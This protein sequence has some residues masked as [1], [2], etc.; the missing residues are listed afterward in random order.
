VLSDKEWGRGGRILHERAGG[1]GGKGGAIGRGKVDAGR[2][3]NGCSFAG[4]GDQ[5]L[6]KSDAGWKRAVGGKG[7]LEWGGG[8]DGGHSGS[9]IGGKLI[10]SS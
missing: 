6:E 9:A 4:D 5:V 1:G 7:G 10:R 3:K 2:R 8:E